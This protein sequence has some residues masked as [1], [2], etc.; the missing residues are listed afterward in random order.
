MKKILV[1]IFLILGVTM[2]LGIVSAD[3]NSTQT[4]ACI[5]AGYQ[6]YDMSCSAGFQLMSDLKCPSL[7]GNRPEVCCK[8]VVDLSRSPR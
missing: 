1:S 2:L 4:N 6:C 8:E 3:D 7:V 5:S